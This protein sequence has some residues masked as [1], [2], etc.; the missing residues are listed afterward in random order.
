M[1]YTK[2]SFLTCT[3]CGAT[4]DLPEDRNH[5]PLW[6]AGWRWIGTQNLYSCPGCPPVI[7]VDAQGRHTLPVS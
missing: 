5:T 7:V 3:N 4:A 6:E 1:A 2:P